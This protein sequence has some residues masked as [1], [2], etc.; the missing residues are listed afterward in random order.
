MYICVQ[1]RS[2]PYS[3]NCHGSAKEAFLKFCRNTLMFCLLSS[4]CTRS[5][6]VITLSCPPSSSSLKVNN[7]SFRHAS[8]CLWNQLPTELRLPTIMKTYHSYLI[9]HTSV[10]HFLHHHCHHPLLL[11]FTPGSKLIF[12]TNPFLHS[13]TFPP[14][15]LTPW[16]PA[17]FC[18]SW[19]RQF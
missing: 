4:L 17:V 1:S 7:H 18:F 11:S 12:S 9:S 8:P 13:S 10:C 14:T 19:A 6:H 2:S 3:L 5:S 16:T 15:G